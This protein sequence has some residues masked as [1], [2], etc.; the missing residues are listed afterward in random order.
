MRLVAF[1]INDDADSY[2]DD[3]D[4]DHGDNARDYDDGDD[5]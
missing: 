1:W 2:T 5:N 3:N 4:V